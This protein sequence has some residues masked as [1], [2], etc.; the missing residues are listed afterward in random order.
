M[1]KLK[2]VKKEHLLVSFGK[3]ECLAVFLVAKGAYLTLISDKL[4]GWPF[5]LSWPVSVMALCVYCSDSVWVV[6]VQLGTFLANILAVI[7]RDILWFIH[8]ISNFLS[9]FIVSFADDKMALFN[10]RVNYASI[11]ALILQSL[12]SSSYSR[13]MQS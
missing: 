4:T 13:I 12:L 10:L 5:F 6:H 1:R 3:G 11:L 8:A 2:W 9:P 7:F